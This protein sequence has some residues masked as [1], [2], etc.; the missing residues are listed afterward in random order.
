M[1]RRFDRLPRSGDGQRRYN[2]YKKRPSEQQQR[3]ERII[4][5]GPVIEA[6]LL[7]VLLGIV[8]YFLLFA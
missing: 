3:I 8:A 1:A 5:A 7:I 2:I 4:R 6:G